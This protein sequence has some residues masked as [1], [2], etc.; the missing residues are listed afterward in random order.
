[1]SAKRYARRVTL[2]SRPVGLPT[3]DNFLIEPFVVNSP[4]S[5]Q[6]LVKVTHFSLDPYMRGR[7]DDAASYAAPVKLGHIM[8]AGA[9]GRVEESASDGIE[10]GDWVY[11]RMGWTEAAVVDASLIQKIP[12]SI[13][14]KSLCLGALGMPGFTG[15]WGLTQHGRPKAGETLVVG[16]VTG[17]VGSMV[18]QLARRLG[19]KTIGIAGSDEKCALAVDKFGVD[20]C[21]NHKLFES[22]NEM[23]SA[24]KTLAPKGV[25]IYFENVGGK[26]FEA[27]VPEMNDF[28]RMI[29]CGMVSWYNEGAMG[30]DART[31]SM[32]VANLWRMI[33]IKKLSVNGFIIS[34]HWSQLSKFV[35]DV[36]PLVASGEIKYIEDVVM[37]IENAP[38]AFIGL[39]QGHNF[40]KLVVKV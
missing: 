15:W 31:D 25:D 20:H 3:V 17:P 26:L 28:G 22:A 37:G 4:L 7:M 9:V 19:L 29:V 1:M 23:Q 8:E 24:I 13:E 11:G 18:V 2:A 32:S 30:A 33:L 36:E 16:A 14:P 21:L 12:A 10:V 40:G 27:V 38:S 35:D 39:L 6:V 5:G 34:D